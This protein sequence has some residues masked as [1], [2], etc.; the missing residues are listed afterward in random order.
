MGVH[1]YPQG[2][3]RWKRVIAKAQRAEVDRVRVSMIGRAIGR[4]LGGWGGEPV[5]VMTTG[6]ALG[7]NI[8]SG[9]FCT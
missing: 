5:V 2:A 3:F 1:S 4:I 8:G 9:K 7:S 6:R